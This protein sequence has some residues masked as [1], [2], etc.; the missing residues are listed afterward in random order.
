MLVPDTAEFRGLAKK[1]GTLKALAILRRDE[2]NQF[3]DARMVRNRIYD[4]KP[5]VESVII[6]GGLHA[7]TL[8]CNLSP[9]PVVIERELELG[10]IFQ[11]PR[12]PAFRLNSRNRPDEGER[13]PGGSGSLNYIPNGLL[14]VADISGDEY[15]SQDDFALA[16]KANLIERSMSFPSCSVSG[17]RNFDGDL[18]VRLRD[19]EDRVRFVSCKRLFVAT[20]IG[21]PTSI[22]VDERRYENGRTAVYTFAEWLRALRFQRAIWR[23]V[24]RLAVIGANDSGKV[25]I[26]HAL[27]QGPGASRSVNLDFVERI[28]WYGQTSYY[29]ES[30]EECERSRYSGI[31]R[32]MPRIRDIEHF[33]RVFANNARATGISQTEPG[34]RVRYISGGCCVS[35]PY[36][37]VVICTGF[38][39]NIDDLFKDLIPR[40]EEVTEPFYVDGEFVARKYTGIEA[41]KVGPVADIPVMRDENL[42]GIPENSAAAFRYVEKTAKLAR[43]MVDKT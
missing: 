26:E 10:G 29:Q 13:K 40:Y 22:P 12:G 2:L 36:D 7:A 31:G 18:S 24:K 35:P 27:G 19:F 34:P 21:E 38:K 16:I 42:G 23:D 32:Y 20:G 25:V 1:V 33:A 39:S 41:Y 17:I 37:M 14:Q 11:L 15:P 5:A 30:F 8:A 4:M 6:G 3:I 9:K 28:D 43:Y